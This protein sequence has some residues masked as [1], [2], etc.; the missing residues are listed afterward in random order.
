MPCSIPTLLLPT[1]HP[2]SGTKVEVTSVSTAT[3][4]QQQTI[5]VAQHQT[6]LKD[7]TTAEGYSETWGKFSSLYNL[8][9]KRTT[10]KNAALYVEMLHLLY[11]PLEFTVP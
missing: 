9:R 11:H 6:T 2:T 4:L 10:E 8:F 3:Q 5:S 1:K 7:I